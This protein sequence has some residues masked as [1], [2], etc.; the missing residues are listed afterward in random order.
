M[1]GEVSFILY[2]TDYCD[3]CEQALD[4]LLSMPELAGAQ[5]SVVDVALD[6]ALAA[7][8][9]ARLPVLL[10]SLGEAS[11]ELDWPFDASAVTASMGE[12][13]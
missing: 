3:L 6:D 5:L 13:K 12:L 9:G 8:Y 2:A 4:L 10:V 7:R 11:R 1:R